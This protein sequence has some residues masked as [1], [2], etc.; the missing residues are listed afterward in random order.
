MRKI[1]IRVLTMVLALNLAGYLGNL[2][3][4]DM[5]PSPAPSP[6]PSPS[7]V[8][9]P[10]SG[11]PGVPSSTDKGDV[12]KQITDAA[13]WAAIVKKMNQQITQ[14][15]NASQ[16]QVDQRT[17][18]FQSSDNDLKMQ[19]GQLY[20]ALNRLN[21]PSDPKYDGLYAQYQSKQ[22]AINA[23][24]QQYLKDLKTIEAS[25]QQQ[26][27]TVKALGDAAAGVGKQI[28]SGVMDFLGGN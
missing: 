17:A 21:G 16:A 19:S 24:Y 4:H 5:P 1:V 28:P 10:A 23:N 15:N 6:A 20:N 8:P 25:R 13:A 14:I 2:Y 7:R 26:I 18:A 3:A 9:P 22:N 27:K 12:M 11:P